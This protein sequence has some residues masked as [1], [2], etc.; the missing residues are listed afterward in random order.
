[1]GDAALTVNAVWSFPAVLGRRP[2]SYSERQAMF[3]AG[4]SAE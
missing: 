3:A 2:L 1:M 4:I